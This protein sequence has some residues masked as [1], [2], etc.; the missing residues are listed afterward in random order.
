MNRLIMFLIIFIISLI[1]FVVS[2]ILIGLNQEPAKC[3]SEV[4]ES[5]NVGITDIRYLTLVVSGITMVCSSVLLYTDI[6]V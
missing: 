3:S 1:M 6:K 2:G 4:P 5:L